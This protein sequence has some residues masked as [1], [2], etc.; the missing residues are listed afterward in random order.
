MHERNLEPEEPA[1]WSLVDQ[2]S[3]FADQPSK[4]RLDIVGLEGD[5]MHARPSPR[6]KAPD[7]RVFARRRNE[8]DPAVADEERGRSDTLLRERVAALEARAEEALI[9]QDR[10]V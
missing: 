5:V 7:V 6:E 1:P 3:T 8:L 9:G 4:R 10:L 2:L